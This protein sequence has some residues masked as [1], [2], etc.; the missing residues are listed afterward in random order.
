MR[1]RLIISVGL[2]IGLV[3]ALALASPSATKRY[4]ADLTGSSVVP[5]QGLASGKG[6]ARFTVTG[7]RLCWKITVSGIDTPVVA[8]IHTGGAVSSGPVIVALGGHF[9]PAGCTTISDDAVVAIGGCGCSGVY[10]D[11]HTKSYP[12]GAIRGSLEVGR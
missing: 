3:P 4:K 2:A 12:T 1:P 10:V 6:S 9:K 11:V 7:H 8:H 5:K